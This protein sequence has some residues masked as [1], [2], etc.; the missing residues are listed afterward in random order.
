MVV[1]TVCFSM[2]TYSIY[3]SF[4]SETAGNYTVN[5]EETKNL[6]LRVFVGNEKEA[7]KCSWAP[8]NNAFRIMICLFAG[9]FAFTGP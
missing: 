7:L 4:D 1:Q 6:P 8:I 3:Q 5:C 2:F 9:L